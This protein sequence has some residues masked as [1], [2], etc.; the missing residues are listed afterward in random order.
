MKQRGTLPLEMAHYAHAFIFRQGMSACSAGFRLCRSQRERKVPARKAV[1]L[2]ETLQYDS[3]L[4][5]RTCLPTVLLLI[6]HAP[7]NF[8]AK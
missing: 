2:G 6:K 3:N 4:Y 1:G 8:R 5:V 7:C